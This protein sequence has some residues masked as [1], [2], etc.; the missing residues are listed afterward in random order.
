MPDYQPI[1]LGPFCNVGV[2]FL[3]AAAQPPLGAQTFHGLPFLIGRTDALASHAFIGFGG[4][5]ETGSPVTVPIGSPAHCLIFAHTLLESQIAAGGA[6]GQVVAHYTFRFAN[7]ERVRTPIRER[8]EISIV[9][10]PYGGT[11]FLA[12]PDQQEWLLGG[13]A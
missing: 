9:P 4:G 7:G 1:D 3:K 11:P 13:D 6:I 12:L 10:P 2:D 8:F 5:A